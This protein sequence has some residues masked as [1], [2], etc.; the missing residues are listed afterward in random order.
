MLIRNIKIISGAFLLA[1]FA[2]F[3]LPTFVPAASAS[4]AAAPAAAAS[5]PAAAAP[6]AAATEAA[7]D[8]KPAV[9]IPVP[10][11]TEADYP[12]IKG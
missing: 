11:L 10:K 6:A 3:M 2:M 9:S 4:E 12:K 1:V 8:A 5:A 7:P